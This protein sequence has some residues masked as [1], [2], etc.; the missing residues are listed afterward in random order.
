MTT[1]AKPIN[2]P[3][4]GHDVPLEQ[5]RF[6]ALV[7]FR[8]D[9][10]PVSTPMLFVPD[11]NRLLVRTA[12]DTGKLKRVAHTPAVLVVPC[13][14]RGRLLGAPSHGRAR[15]LGED[16]VA[17]ALAHLHAR[18]PV[19]GRLSSLVRRLRGQRNV[20]IEVTLGEAVA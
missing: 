4:A 18:H 10:T 15:I 11:G 5:A 1:T 2:A 17:P 12:R 7:T 14:S 9:G 13:D 16:A 20:I 19:A 6:I 3:A 8:R